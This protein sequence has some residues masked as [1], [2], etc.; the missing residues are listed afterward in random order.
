MFLKQDDLERITSVQDFPSYIDDLIKR[1][2]GLDGGIEAIRLRKGLVKNLI[3]EALP[4]SRFVETHYGAEP[5]VYVQL[6]IGNQNYDAIIHDKR[7]NTENIE[8]LEVTLTTVVCASDG[9]EDYLFRWHLHQF[10]HSGTG[11]I[12]NLGS[13]NKGMNVELERNGV[14]QE[15]VLNHERSTVKGAIERKLKEP[16]HYP[17]NTALIISFDDSYS[18]DREDNQR[19]LREVLSRMSKDLNKHNFNL[20]A[21]VGIH[22][23]LLIEQTNNT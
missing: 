4:I 18:F 7:N 23:G 21:I 6:K 2:Q 5:N 19:N 10:G 1:I 11:K 15:E 17:N 20:V 16:G 9:Y 22:K 8:Y 12:T 14:S 13:K 3:E